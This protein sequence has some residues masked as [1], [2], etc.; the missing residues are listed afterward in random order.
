MLRN[1]VWIPI[2]VAGCA[3]DAEDVPTSEDESEL[4]VASTQIWPSNEIP[5]CFE[6]SGRDT[7]KAIVRDALRATWEAEANITFTGF[8]TCNAGTNS[9]IRVRVADEWPLTVSLGKSLNN[10]VNGMVLNFDYTF[11]DI[12]GN[13]PFAGCLGAMRL[14]CIRAHAIHEFGHALGFAHE[15]DRLDTP[16]SCTEPGF[17]PNGDYAIGPWD[18]GSVM[19]YCNPDQVP[20]ALSPTDAWG[21]QKFYGAH[22]PIAASK[23]AFGQFDLATRMPYDHLEANYVNHTTTYTRELPLGGVSAMP[24]IV[25]TAAGDVHAIVRGTDGA[26]WARRLY[27]GQSPTYTQLGPNPV[28]GNPV[29]VSRGAGL[30]DVIVRGTDGALYRKAFFGGAWSPVYQLVGS[31]PVRFIGTPS[32]TVLGPDRVDVV[33]RGSDHRLYHSTF[34]GSTWTAMQAISSTQVSSDATATS[35]DG[36]RLDVFVRGADGS[37]LTATRLGAAWTPYLQLGT[38]VILGAPSA[39]SRTWNSIDVYVRGTDNGLYTKSWTGSAWTG[40]VGL[41]GILRGSPTAVA[42]GPGRVDVFVRGTD[43]RVHVKNWLGV[44]WNPYVRIETQ[45]AIR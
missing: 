12:F 4:Y 25:S 13:Q 19:N 2:L 45:Y 3:L 5:V 7:E 31:A 36:Q 41:G 16:S 20:L 14:T 21:A 37:L 1:L 38:N 22:R 23:R 34:N 27:V 30:V 40:Y 17:F 35:W 28:V 8:G 39:V 18:L 11:R 33:V 44:G 42:S 26:L 6:T 32:V 24:T 29:A 43:D 9:G 15:Q 10:V